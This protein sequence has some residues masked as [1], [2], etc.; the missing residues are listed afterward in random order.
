MAMRFALVGE[1]PYAWRSM[2]GEEMGG[3]A[4]YRNGAV[5]TRS[6]SVRGDLESSRPSASILPLKVILFPAWSIRRITEGASRW[7]PG[8]ARMTSRLGMD[9]LWLLSGGWM[10]AGP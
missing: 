1:S 8:M 7:W 6:V 10:R 5:E 4:A 3:A 9:D 2:Q